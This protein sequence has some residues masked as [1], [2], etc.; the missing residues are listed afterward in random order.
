M[1]GPRACRYNK[2]PE[3]LGVLLTYLVTAGT[4]ACEG[5][6]YKL[7]GVEVPRPRKRSPSPRPPAAADTSSGR[8]RGVSSKAKANTPAELDVSAYETQVMQRL[9]EYCLV[10]SW[11]C[12]WWDD[13]R[14]RAQELT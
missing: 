14:R 1:C 12:R 13:Q 2:T 9:A 10:P 6:E 5:G 3:Q 4:L 8:A 11:Q 7:R